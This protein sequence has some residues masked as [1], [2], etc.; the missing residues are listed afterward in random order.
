MDWLLVKNGDWYLTADETW[1]SSNIDDAVT[2]LTKKEALN[3]RNNFECI[4][5]KDC[6]KEYLPQKRR[7]HKRAEEWLLQTWRI[8]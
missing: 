8:K 5:G 1:F 6:L 4:C 7:D 2:F 3:Y